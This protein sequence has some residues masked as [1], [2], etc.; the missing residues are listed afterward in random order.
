MNINFRIILEPLILC[1]AVALN[2]KQHSITS[3]IAIFTL[4]LEQS[5]LT[6]LVLMSNFEKLTSWKSF[7]YSV[8]I[9]EL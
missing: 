8:W 2:Q 7:E 6:M 1:A 5:F 4:T 3:Y 9:G